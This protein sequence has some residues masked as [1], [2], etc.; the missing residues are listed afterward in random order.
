MRTP[1]WSHREPGILRGSSVTGILALVLGLL[2]WTAAP[3]AQDLSQYPRLKGGEWGRAANLKDAEGRFQARQEHS[4]VELNGF[5]YLIGGFV[6]AQPPPKPTEN[7]PEPFLFD[8]TD[9]VLAYIPAGHA[10]AAGA[11]AGTWRSLDKASR[12][13]HA[14]YHHLI[15]VAHKGKIWS[16]G[17]HGG[18][19]FEPTETV[20]VFTPN[21]ADA[22]EGSWGMVNVSDGKAC[23]QASLFFGKKKGELSGL[24]KKTGC[25]TLPEPRSAGAA[26]SLG[27]RIYVIGGVV[28]NTGAGDPVNASIRTTTSVIS[29]DTTRYPL[30]WQVMPP[31]R[32]PREHFNAVVVGG[33]IWVLHGRGEV[34][35]HMRG[36][37][38]WAP[39]EPAW[40]REPDAP[41]GTSANVL[42][43]V[44][45]CIYSF[46]GEFIAS[47][48][49]GTVT[50]SQVF[51]VP[52]RTWRLLESTVQDKPVDA[53]GATS[54]HGTYGI[55]FTEGGVKKIM[56][57]GGASLAWF[58]PMSRVHVF[59]PPARC[60]R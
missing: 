46:G 47:N 48:V 27:N 42:G 44:G 50:N 41:I 5:V 17:G 37:E 24:A 33:R 7:N 55:P 38:S 52:S 16:F 20:Y 32:E 43:A 58:A 19:V 23:G 60:D 22:P 13:P 26:V 31:L 8:A 59:T 30:T 36:V 51:H 18:I 1:S 11:Q 53:G 56:A 29:V 45:E 54:K 49:T 4:S 9:E 35:T 12:F 6:P 25:L 39:G 10:A 34:S 28:P 2:A 57:P 21:R 40:R 15:S 3:S 14:E